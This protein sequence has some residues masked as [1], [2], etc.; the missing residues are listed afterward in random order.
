MEKPPKSLMSF[1][2]T[3]KNWKLT[4]SHNLFA[5]RSRQGLVNYSRIILIPLQVFKFFS[6]FRRLSHKSVNF[7]RP[8][9]LCGERTAPRG[10]RLVKTRENCIWP[11]R[12]RAKWLSQKLE[13][14]LF[15]FLKKK[16]YDW[17]TP[18][19]TKAPKGDTKFRCLLFK[20]L[21]C[22]NSLCVEYKV[23]YVA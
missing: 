13:K 22:N 23:F 10:K 9:F 7:Q 12:A 15:E 18:R 17:L 5:G 6:F 19:P 11:L 21:C 14:K 1:R 4:I 16:C 2:S 8:A 3:K 20:L